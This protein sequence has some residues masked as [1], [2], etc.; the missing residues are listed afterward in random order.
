MIGDQRDF[1][2][3]ELVSPTA[4]AVSGAALTRASWP[5]IFAGVVLVLAIEVLLAVLGAGIGLGLVNPGAGGTPEASSFG[6]GAVAAG[7]GGALASPRAPLLA[8]WVAPR[9][10]IGSDVEFGLIETFG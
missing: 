9:V 8:R 5:A 3:A 7:V 1:S 2:A 4:A 10:T 6:I